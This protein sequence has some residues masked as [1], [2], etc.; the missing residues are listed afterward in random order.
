MN[1]HHLNSSYWQNYKK[2]VCNLPQ[3]LFDVAVGMILGDATM[4]H[5]SFDA[6]LKFEQGAKQKQFGFHLFQLFSEYCFMQSPAPRYE[7]NFIKIKSY[8]FKTFSFPDFTRLYLLFYEKAGDRRI[9][10]IK[11]GLILNELTP[12]GLAYWIM[13]DGSLQKDCKT[14]ILHTQ[15]FTHS[16]NI[17]LSHELNENFGF[18]S[19]VIPHKKK[20][21]CN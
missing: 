8:W 11:K 9:K 12:R 1:G 10:R 19:H 4:Y 3:H 17:I 7:T 16:E 20:I 14:M 5:V 21:L 18:C 15:G 2:T 6:I 13:Y